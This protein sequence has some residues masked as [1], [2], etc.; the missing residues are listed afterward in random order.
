MISTIAL[1]VLVL[2]ET[3]LLLLLLRALGILRQK[4]V[5]A[6]TEQPLELGGLDVG[7]QAPAFV[8][9][10]QGGN[11]VRLEDFQG[12][13][14]VLAFILPGCSGCIGTLDSLKA[15]LQDEHDLAVIVISDA[16]KEANRAYAIKHNLQIPVLTPDPDLV[17]VYRVR[18]F[19][20]VFVLNEA[21][22]IRTKGVV[23]VSEQLRS[24]LMTA[25]GSIP[26]HH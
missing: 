4:G 15:V 24:M 3:V 19:P 8:A 16:D 22:V 7:E 23:N 10:D 2:F 12:R 11:P 20:F 17:S 14:C 25:N 21:G 6:A 13:Q 1:W 26:A 9:I 18:T 5:L